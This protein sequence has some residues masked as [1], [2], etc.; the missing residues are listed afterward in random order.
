[1]PVNTYNTFMNCIQIL[2]MN[3]LL[4]FRRNETNI[5]T[6]EVKLFTQVLFIKKKKGVF[7]YLIVNKLQKYL[8]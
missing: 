6:F 7:N 4:H 8:T 5:S 1:M 2:D 3:I